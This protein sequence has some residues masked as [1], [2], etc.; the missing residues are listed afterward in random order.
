MVLRK[1]IMSLTKDISKFF[2]KSSQNRG[3]GD[4]SK[5]WKDRKKMTEDKSSSGSLN[6]MAD[7]A[8]TERLTLSE[9]IAILFDYVRN[10]E[11]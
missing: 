3:L 4:Q 8:F 9:C 11:R 7:E 2:D 10:V 6:D 5:T 1:I